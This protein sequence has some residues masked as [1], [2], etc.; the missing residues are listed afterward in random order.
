MNTTFYN[1]LRQRYMEI[2]N[3][4]V[5]VEKVLVAYDCILVFQEIARTEGLL[6]LE[7]ACENLDKNDSAQSIFRDLIFLVVDGTDPDI[8]AEIGMNK[9]ISSKL[10][11]CDGLICLMYFR[12][13]LLIQE[14]YSSRLIEEYMKSVLP[15][16]CIEAL[17][18]RNQA[19][20]MTK[21]AI[22]A[23]EDA[24][25]V[26]KL[27]NDDIDIN[28]ADYTIIN[29]TA[30]ALLMLKDGDMERLLRDINYWD[31]AKAMKGFPGKVRKRVF[32]NLS[33]NLQVELAKDMDYMGPVRVRD[34]EMYCV[35]IL[36][37]I[38]K[39]SSNCELSANDFSVMREVLDMHKE[40]WK[41]NKL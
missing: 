41:R 23:K 37:L 14:G 28:N 15:K 33:V 26:L 4:E 10:S 18:K 25:R 27:C 38:L 7:K 11:G 2:G 17:E 35:E 31:L 8:L 32:D 13:S 29:Q 5:I 24:E 9:C 16:A 6:S 34:I 22:E 36:E 1:E 3:I 40:E 39:L 12:G 20:G 19:N 21:E 30:R